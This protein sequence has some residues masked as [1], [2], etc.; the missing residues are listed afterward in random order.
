LATLTTIDEVGHL[1]LRTLL[2]F[3]TA[4]LASRHLPRRLASF[5]LRRRTLL[6]LLLDLLTPRIRLVHH[7]LTTR[8]LG[9][10]HLL[11]CLTAILSLLRLRTSLRLTLLLPTA[12]H[13]LPLLTLRTSLLLARLSSLPILPLRRSCLALGLWSLALSLRPSASAVSAA[14]AFAFAFAL[15]ENIAV[16]T[17]ERYKTKRGNRRQL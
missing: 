9:L 2:V 10:T 12:P 7:L 8:I 13:L 3:G 16:G 4:L 15:A 5:R 1:L 6:P 11:H 17:D 14:I